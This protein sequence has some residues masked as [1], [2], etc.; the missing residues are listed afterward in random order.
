MCLAPPSLPAAPHTDRQGLPLCSD[1]EPSH[2]Q[3]PALMSP[4]RA[5]LQLRAPKL[6]GIHF[7][8]I[9]H[10]SPSQLPHFLPSDFSALS[11]LSCKRENSHHCLEDPGSPTSSQHTPCHRPS[12]SPC[13]PN[14]SSLSPSSPNPS[15]PNRSSL[16]PSSLGASR[17]KCA[18]V[19]RHR[20]G[21][22]NYLWEKYS[23]KSLASKDVKR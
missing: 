22:D 21:P 6:E 20:F 12:L 7:P 18:V 9:P 14:P 10:H 15:S 5:P 11:P 16:S 8:A 19:D 13:S 23:H 17:F 1:R 4:P 3:N 2:S